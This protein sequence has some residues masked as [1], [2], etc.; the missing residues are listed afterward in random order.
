[1][2]VGCEV[3]MS[4]AAPIG[5][6][7]G[8]RNPRA[9]LELRDRAPQIPLIIDAGIGLPSHA[10][11]VMEWGFAGVL[12]NTAVSR[13]DNPVRMAGAF[14]SA[15]RAGRSAFLAGPMSVQEKAIASTP[16]IGRPFT[17]ASLQIGISGT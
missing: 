3:L 4:W 7:Q 9:L 12:L 5:T 17:S 14:A 15:I 1:M 8:P 11:Q 2:N 13:A 16:E 10:C 6:G